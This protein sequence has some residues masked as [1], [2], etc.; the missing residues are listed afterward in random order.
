MSCWSWSYLLCY[1]FNWVLQNC[2][3]VNFFRSDFLLQIL[4]WG[5]QTKIFGQPGTLDP[6]FGFLGS[7]PWRAFKY[8]GFWDQ[9]LVI[10]IIFGSGWVQNG[11]ESSG[12]SGQKYRSASICL[13]KS[14]AYK[15]HNWFEQVCKM[16]WSILKYIT[17]KNHNSYRWHL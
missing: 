7:R 5:L 17:Y 15:L 11:I 9:G 10:L 1:I 3:E 16:I 13:A 8:L 4:V 6:N 12:F 14:I 2:E